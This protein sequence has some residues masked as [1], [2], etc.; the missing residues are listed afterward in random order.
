LNT[1]EDLLTTFRRKNIVEDVGDLLIGVFQ[2][3]MNP[4][5]EQF[6]E[7][8]F[9]GLDTLSLFVKKDLAIIAGRPSAGK[10]A[11]II[12]L[13]AKF[14]EKNYV[15][16][17]DSLETSKEVVLKRL[18][19]IKTGIPYMRIRRGQLMENEHTTI[20]DTVD[21][22]FSK[23]DQFV[24]DTL[25]LEALRNTVASFKPDIVF[26]DYLQILKT[27]KTF[28]SR[29]D[30][31]DYITQ[32]LK[33]IAMAHNTLVIATAQLNRSIEKRD[34]KEPQLS[35]LRESGMIEQAADVV[36]FL[37]KD[38]KDS[39]LVHFDVKKNREGMITDVLF[40]YNANI[41]KFEEIGGE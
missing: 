13:F 27:K 1:L 39:E 36:A 14:L 32:S 38:K 33:D 26:V 10:T 15:I 19:S 7:S 5:Q 2:D 30:E 16:L 40:E 3:I 8:G 12:N 29:L 31:L 25:N 17:L 6:I 24:I 20:V 9:Y 18:I 34:S 4:K 22:L 41:L 35:D 23:K 21:Y 37:R 11:M 28:R